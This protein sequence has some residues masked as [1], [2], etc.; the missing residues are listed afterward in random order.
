LEYFPIRKTT[1]GL[2]VEGFPDASKVVQIKGQEAKRLASMSLHK[3]DLDFAESCLDAINLMEGDRVNIRQALWRSAVV[4]YFKCFDGSSKAR[5]YPLDKGKIFRSD[6]V[7]REVHEYFKNLRNKHFVHD[8]NPFS[9]CLPG[10]VLTRGDKPYKVEKIVCL[11]V[12]SETLTQENFS[13]LKL[14]VGKSLE[15]VVAEFDRICDRITKELEKE[16]YETLL[17]REGITFVVPSVSD[18]TRNRASD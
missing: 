7:G 10:A 8:E 1:E 16:S 9:Q 17:E 11:N 6:P 3:E 4:N 2:H 5:T 13:N 12:L 14:L 15:W 18:A